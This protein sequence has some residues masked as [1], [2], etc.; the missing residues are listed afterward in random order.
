[1]S[2]C[3]IFPGQGTQFVGMN[4][5][6]DLDSGI[7]QGIIRLME[8]GPPDELNRTIN[9]QPAIFATSVALWEKS[10]LPMPDF[11]MGH[12]L[13]EYMSLVVAGVL[14]KQDAFDLVR[15]RAESME[16]AQPDGLGGMAAVLGL[17]ADV[18]DS[19]IRGVED[20]WIANING[21]RQVVIS[22][23]RSSIGMAI[24][25]LKKAGARRVVP[26]KVSVASHCPL[27][28]KARQ[29]LEMHLDTKD[30]ER[31]R[32]RVVFNATAREAQDPGSIKTLL[33]RQ[34]VEPVLWEDSVRY[35]VSQGIKRFVEV[36]PRSV[37]SSLVKR[38][39]PDAQV[40]AVTQ[41]S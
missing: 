18:V 14:S 35:V 40:E 30:L 15:V 20:L 32:T 38:I 10:G 26:L 21:G 22:G 11:V 31:P 28:A 9:A 2:Y 36:G 5:G 6:L 33:S 13:G 23:M 8:S 3:L 41:G 19:A 7:G 4:K 1:M 27:M 17:G 25:V 24:P 39:Y 12:S 16:N 34:L 29:S 37:L